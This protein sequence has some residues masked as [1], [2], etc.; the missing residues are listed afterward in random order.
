MKIIKTKKTV[1]TEFGRHEEIRYAIVDDAGKIIDDAQGY[2]Y[3]T[4][5]K[6]SKAMWW[7]FKG[8]DKQSNDKLNWWKKHK[9]LWLSIQDDLEY[10]WKE[11]MIGDFTDD[12]IKSLY[13][14][15]AEDMHIDLP[16]DMLKFAFTKY[17]SKMI[18][19]AIH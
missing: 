12:D 1:E 17:G 5:A 19:K 9:E 2:G 13:K 3:R 10:W 14:K 16:D 4:Y 6:A 18:D 8:G 7:K 11:I 15:K